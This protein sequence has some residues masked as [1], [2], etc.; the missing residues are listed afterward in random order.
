MLCWV[1]TMTKASRAPWSAVLSIRVFVNFYDF[2]I[3]LLTT[4][5]N[6][7]IASCDHICFRNSKKK[8]KKPNGTGIVLV[9]LRQICEHISFSRKFCFPLLLWSDEGILCNCSYFPFIYLIFPISHCSILFCF[10]KRVD[11]FSSFYHLNLI[12]NGNN[13]E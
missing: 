13:Y 6:V 12:S 9:F 10:N 7:G 3:W 1:I 4:L 2:L 5:I 8:K 11:L